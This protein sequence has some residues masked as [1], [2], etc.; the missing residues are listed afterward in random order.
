[1]K[2]TV[3]PTPHNFNGD[4]DAHRKY[5]A[6]LLVPRGL[7]LRPGDHS[8]ILIYTGMQEVPARKLM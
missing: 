5:E 1:M 8:A 6:L 4:A 7:C 2:L 3:L